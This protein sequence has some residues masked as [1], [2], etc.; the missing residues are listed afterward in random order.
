VTSASPSRGGP[1]V[2]Q[3]RQTSTPPGFFALGR[4][5]SGRLLHAADEAFHREVVLCHFVGVVQGLWQQR[6]S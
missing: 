3:R 5:A 1:I 4:I 6:R 2:D